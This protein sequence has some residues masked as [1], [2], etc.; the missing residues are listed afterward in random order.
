MYDDGLDPDAPF[1]DDRWELYHVAEDLT[2]C[3]DLADAEPERLATMVEL[4]WREARA[5]QVLPLD[6]RPLAALE[7]PRPT[8]ARDR[9][10]YRYFPHA[11]PVPESVAVNVRNRS[12]VITV[13]VEV[14]A[15]RPLEGV[16]LAQGSVLGGWTFYAIDGALRYEHNVA[17]RDRH[18]VRSDVVVGAGRHTLAFE[19]EGPGDF[20]GTGRLFVDEALVGEAAIPFVTPA[21]LSIT[22]A[23]LTCGYELGPA[24]SF[25]YVA[26]FRCTGRILEAVVDVSGTPYRDLRSE[27]AAIL[28]AE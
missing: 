1:S 23:V 16:L 8:R 7:H 20:T 28:A 10:R 26:P 5:H 19:F 4:W 9:S 13:D 11:A 22:G 18:L 6:N 27:V 12:H 17:N 14:P 24:V 2:E 3:H 15:G 21:R 25:D